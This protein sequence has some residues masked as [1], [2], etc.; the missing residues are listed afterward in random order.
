MFKL[1]GWWWLQCGVCRT[2]FHNKLHVRRQCRLERLRC[3][4]G[5]NHAV[6]EQVVGCRGAGLRVHASGDW[7]R[8][9]HPFLAVI[10]LKALSML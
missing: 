5:S 3:H 10:H 6:T 2:I 1:V 8:R 9:R 4:S 7:T